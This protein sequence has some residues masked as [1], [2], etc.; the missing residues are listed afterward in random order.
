MKVTKNQAEA[1]ITEDS[2]NIADALQEAGKVPADMHL[3]NMKLNKEYHTL[4]IGMKCI[5]GKFSK[6]GTTFVTQKQKHNVSTM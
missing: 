3:R 5:E 2:T 1:L 6:S 4:D